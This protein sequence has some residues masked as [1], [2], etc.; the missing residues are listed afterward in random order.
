MAATR[1]RRASIGLQGGTGNRFGTHLWDAIS[2]LALLP[3]WSHDGKC[4]TTEN[5]RWQ[6]HEAQAAVPVTTR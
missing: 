2:Y 1:S 5:L 3:G 4:D 6:N